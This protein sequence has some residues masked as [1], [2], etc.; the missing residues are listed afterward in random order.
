[1]KWAQGI[2]AACVVSIA[3]GV[4]F[5]QVDTTVGKTR[6]QNPEVAD[7]VCAAGSRSQPTITGKPDNY[8]GVSG[9]GQPVTGTGYGGYRSGREGL[10]YRGPDPKPGWLDF[11]NRAR[12]GRQRR[13]ASTAPPHLGPSLARHD[14]LPFG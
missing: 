7:I 3:G 14:D 1:M 11:G 4:A 8:S 5:P 13:T 12:H 2:L 9:P 10:M 6:P